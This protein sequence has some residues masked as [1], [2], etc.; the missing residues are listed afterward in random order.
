MVHKDIA[1]LEAELFKREVI[2]LNRHLV[3]EE[4]RNTYSESTAMHYL[5]DLDEHLIYTHDETSLRPYCAS[6]TLFP[7]LLEGT[8]NLGGVSKAPKNLRSFCGAF[9]NLVYQVAS[10]FAGAIATV[11]FL[12]YFDYFAK[13]EYGERYYTTHKK[14]II[15]ELQGVVFSLNQPATA[16]GNQ[17]VFWNI[18]V[19]DENYFKALF[20]DFVFPC[21]TK[22]DYTTIKE[23]QNVFMEWF[24][25]AR[26][27][28][29][30]TFPVVTS[31]YLTSKEDKLPLDKA[32]M[33]QRAKEMSKGLSFFHYQS[34]SADSLSSCCRLRSELADNTFSYSLGAGGVVAGSFQVI[35]INFNRFY[36][37]YTATELP[38]LIDRVHK[39]LDAHR[40]IYSRYITAG[41]LPVYTA[42]Y[43]HL[44]KQF[45]TIGINGMLEAYEYAK[46]YE[47]TTLSKE[48]F[49]SQL[50]KIIKDKNT[51]AKSIY[52]YRFNTEFVPAE[53]LG[54]KNSKWDKQLGL[55]SPRECYNSYFFEVEDTTLSILDKMY[56]HGDFITQYL[57][58]GS[59]CHINLEQL[60]SQKQ[61]EHLIM[62]ACQLGVPYWTTN[63]L[64]TICK[65][66]GYINP[67]TH[68]HCTECG[69]KEID[70][71]TRIIG[72]LK[73][74]SAY[75]K[76]RRDEAVKRAYTNRMFNTFTPKY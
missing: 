70:Y 34:D 35:T 17:S 61:A 50:L 26:T 23:L 39:Y 74:I 10:N 27:T 7:F 68:N 9:V 57:D 51:D 65:S 3:Q 20:G 42:G 72:Y 28:E 69:C 71:A 13:K 55:F 33:E 6:I 75:A 2:N 40:R 37:L 44:E 21:G 43:M 22:P 64:C 52:G 67:Q 4:L 31:A 47:K 63:V 62:L 11:E 41:L 12:M 53:N 45:G 29:L 16:R 46:E 73:P 36:Q 66:C 60:P 1:V 54:V 49:F 18:S 5:K 24:T 58:G 32:F 56:I 25:V 8:K 76:G 15:Q 59:A 30:L 19:Y 48:V 38:S 14:A